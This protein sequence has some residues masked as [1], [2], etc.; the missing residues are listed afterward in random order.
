MNVINAENGML[1]KLEM[2]KMNM[3]NAENGSWLKLKIEC[4]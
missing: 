4:D 1:L 2:L 3:I